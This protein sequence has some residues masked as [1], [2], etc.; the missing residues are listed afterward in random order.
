MTDEQGIESDVQASDQGT[1]TAEQMAEVRNEAKTWRKKLR[2]AEAERDQFRA[3]VDALTG[4]RDKAAEERDAAVAER[5]ALRQAG[6]LADMTR[7]I[8]TAH[9]VDA[10]VLRGSTRE[11]LE[12]HAE[13]LKPVYAKAN[14]PF[15]PTIGD[16]PEQTGTD[17]AA[18]AAELFGN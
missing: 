3:Q 12:A 8:A 6:D 17:A 9:G 15:A 14:G 1:F 5:D 4:E 2:D 10:A 7:E 18:F 13:A 16:R 11:E